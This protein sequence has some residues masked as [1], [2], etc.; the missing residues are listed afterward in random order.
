[1]ELDQNETR[2]GAIWFFAAGTFALLFTI[3]LATVDLRLTY[4][5]GE[6]ERYNVMH[7]L[8]LAQTSLA[9]K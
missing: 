5:N 3:F 2:L 1:M 4:S 7:E 8:R 6:E 9:T